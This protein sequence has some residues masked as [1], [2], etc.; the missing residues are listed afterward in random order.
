MSV[1]CRKVFT[2]TRLEDVELSKTELC[3]YFVYQGNL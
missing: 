2:E 1:I 3:K